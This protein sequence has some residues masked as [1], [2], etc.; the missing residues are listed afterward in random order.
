MWRYSSP[1]DTDRLSS[2]ELS[3]SDIWG[4]IDLLLDPD[5]S[6]TLVGTLEPFCAGKRPTFVSPLLCD[7]ASSYF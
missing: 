5:G 1:A 4:W 3:E 7:F 2:M 6:R